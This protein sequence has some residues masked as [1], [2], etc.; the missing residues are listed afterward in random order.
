MNLQ[1]WSSLINEQIADRLL[2][3]PGHAVKGN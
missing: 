3:E 1:T 2:S